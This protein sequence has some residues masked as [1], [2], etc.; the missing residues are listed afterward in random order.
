MRVVPFARRHAP[1]GEI[2]VYSDAG[3]GSSQ[4]EVAELCPE[5]QRSL[6]VRH[7]RPPSTREEMG[8]LNNIEDAALE[9]M[10]SV[11]LFLDGWGGD[12]FTSASSTLDVPVFEI[13]NSR[14]YLVPPDWAVV[15]S[16]RLVPPGPLVGLNFT[17]HGPDF[18]GM[19]RPALER[20]LGRLLTIPGVRFAHFYCTGFDY[21]HWPSRERECRAQVAAEELRANRIV[22]GW[23]ER[24]IP[25]VDQPLAIVAA[26]LARCS[27]FIGV[28]NGLKHLA[29]A[30]GVPRTVLV[31]VL[32]DPLFVVRWI[33]DYHRVVP[34][35]SKLEK[36]NRHAEEARAIVSGHT[37]RSNAHYHNEQQKH[38]RLRAEMTSGDAYDK[39]G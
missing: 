24:I 28:D 37:A 35:D 22:D 16:H 10:K 2:V 1:E 25:I 3:G 27:Y 29:W 15:E 26:L 38:V 18:I 13:F 4:L 23:N 5:V 12:F 30:L 7:K 6:P 32:P 9:Q 33:P 19:A 8:D 31:P 11:D 39:L 20:L 17:K 36:V 14:P 34:L 21:P